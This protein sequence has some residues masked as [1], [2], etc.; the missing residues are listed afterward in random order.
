MG[1]SISTLRAGAGRLAL[2]RALLPAVGALGAQLGGR[3]GAALA[4]GLR[5]RPPAAMLALAPLLIGPPASATAL[6]D[7][8]LGVL[9]L[10]VL[11]RAL[12]PLAAVLPG[13]WRA[14][15]AMPA[16]AALAALVAAALQGSGLLLPVLLATACDL[17]GRRLRD[18][19]P[20]AVCL[21][22]GA[23]LR[24]DVGA[25]LLGGGRDALLP[26]T[27]GAGLL[28]TALAAARAGAPGGVPAGATGAGRAERVRQ[29]EL[30]LLAS[31]AAL[32]GLALA[33]ATRIGVLGA[34]P[35]AWAVLGMPLLGLAGLA[36]LAA[37]DCPRE[38]QRTGRLRAVAV[39]AA[40][41]W[42]VTLATAAWLAGSG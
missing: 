15:P 10:L 5:L 24:V 14:V 30:G 4:A 28:L 6:R 38:A 2:P 32:L 31:F 41:G 16:A 3:V 36:V 1:P 26:L 23:A 19:V 27:V 33:L 42:L 13:P 39:L 11:E 18:A 17:V 7:L 25:L 9:L 21:A 40:G 12:P 22:A 35:S 29:L 34:T 20:L 37:A 8:V